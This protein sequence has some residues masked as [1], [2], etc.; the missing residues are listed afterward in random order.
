MGD[1]ENGIVCGRDTDKKFVA[2]GLAQAAIQAAEGKW[3]SAT[4][5]GV[6][7]H[8]DGD[9]YAGTYLNW[10]SEKRDWCISRQLWW[11]HRIPIWKKQVT[12]EE[13]HQTL[14][15]L[16]PHLS[17]N[18]ICVRIG[19]SDGT[20]RLIQETEAPLEI[21][22]TVDLMVCLQDEQALDE[23][24]QVLETEGFEQDPDVLDTWF[25][26]ALWPHSTLGWPDPET[27]QVED[28]QTT[29]GAVGNNPNCLDS[30]FP[31]SCLVT[32]R[33]I[34]TLWVARMIIMGLYNLGDMPFTDVFIHANILDGKG[35][36]MSKSKGNGIDPVDIIEQYG[37]D[38]MRYVLCELQTGM[39]DIRLPIQAVSPFTGKMVDLG[40]AEHGKTIF[41]YICP[42]S[43]KEFDVTGAMEGIPSAKIISERFDVGVHFCTKLWNAARL[44]FMN[45]EQYSFVP[46]EAAQLQEADRWILSRLSKTIR[47]VNTFLEEY[48]PSAAINTCRS[49]FWGELCDWYLEMI[50]GNLIDES[51]APA[52]RQVLA[53]VLDQVLSLL[54][55]F[56][57]FITETLWQ[58]LNEL[59][60]ERGITA[61][62]SQS[63]LLVKGVWPEPTP[64]WEEEDLEKRMDTVQDIVRAIR[65]VRSKHGL[66]PRKPLRVVIR[67]GKLQEASFEPLIDIIKQIA[68]LESLDLSDQDAPTGDAARA[69]VGDLEIFVRG[70][71][72]ME[73]ERARLKKQRDDLTKRM[74]A[75]RKKL[76]NENFVKKAK[77]EIV[78]K[79]RDKL[80]KMETELHAVKENLQALSSHES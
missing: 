38:A 29:L 57:P 45:L 12:G 23:C 54:H 14:K 33:D 62:L 31:G 58:S 4:G 76:S 43:G 46:R 19:L 78:Q 79:E 20:S 21:R 3:K 51:K 37:T 6:E 70:A 55:P 1:V 47:K 44:A 60:P 74:A 30:Y 75:S 15:A 7:F 71:V 16:E 77:N 65:N 26:S 2:P 10:L 8:P 64:Q 73:K 42:Q 40:K 9:R 41:T 68:N 49:F 36:R 50:K 80:E 35:E 53:T 63:G 39:Q 52:T 11:G 5:R 66:S 67:G 28:G 69:V 22:E 72:D 13:Y 56:V 61:P 48:N 18:D 27:A 59:A 24:G 32:G 25:S 17:R 34:V